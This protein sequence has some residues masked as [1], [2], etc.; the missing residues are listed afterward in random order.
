MSSKKNYKKIGTPNL[1]ILLSAAS[2][3][4]Q[5]CGSTNYSS[6]NSVTQSQSPGTFSIPPKVDVVVVEDDTGRMAEPYSSISTQMTAFV[7]SLAAQNWNY[8]FAVVPLT[9]A[10]YTFQATASTQDVN[11]GSYWTPPFAGDPMSD[12]EIES[13]NPSIFSTLTAYSGLSV[14]TFNGF[15]NQSE[16]TNSLTGNEPGFSNLEHSFTNQI[17]S[18]SGSPTSFVRHLRGYRKRYFL[19][20]S[21]LRKRRKLAPM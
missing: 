18:Y 15:I 8:H 14:P 21:M 6:V 7:N 1:I 16:I 10:N 13:L 17:Q 9:N 3:V 20:E 5:A 12:S 19:C 2:L 4:F 11:Y